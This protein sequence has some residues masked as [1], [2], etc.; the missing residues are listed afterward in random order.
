MTDNLGIASDLGGFLEDSANQAES[1][2]PR[3]ALLTPDVFIGFEQVL[4]VVD[5]AYAAI[6]QGAHMAFQPEV[7]CDIL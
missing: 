7:R 1:D 6:K 2:G 5:S 4:V 3:G